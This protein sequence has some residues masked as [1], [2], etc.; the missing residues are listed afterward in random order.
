MSFPETIDLTKASIS[1]LKYALKTTSLTSVELVSRYLHRIAQYDMRGPGLNSVP[2][3]NANVMEEAQ[4]SDDYRASGKPPRSLEG[5]PFTVKDSFKVQGMTVAA[6]SPAFQDLIASDDAFIVQLLRQA[7]A[8]VLGKT[9]MP[10]MADGG[11]QRG[12]Y[13]RAE[14]PCNLEY[15]TT[16]FYSGSSSGCG[17]ST[18][19]SFAAFGLAGE[20]VSSGRAPASNNALVGYSPSRGVI[21]IRG[22]WPLYPTCDVVVPHTKSTS[23]LFD[24]L[25]VIVA[26]D[27]HPRNLDFWRA[28]NSVRIPSASTLRPLDYHMLEDAS[29][30]QGRRIAVPKCFLGIGDQ[31]LISIFSPEV[32]KLFK[33]AVEDLKALGATVVETDFPLLE[34]YAKQDFAG[35]SI[36][37]PGLSKEW[38]SL[39]RCQLM[40][41]AWNDFLRDNGLSKCP[42]LTHVDM[43]AIQPHIA[44]LD[45][46]SGHSVAQNQ[47]RY[48]EMLEAIRI[49]NGSIHE[50]PGCRESLQALED[51]RKSMYDNW[52][53]TNGYYL[54]A[55]PT[56][57]DV[58]CADADENV[59]L[60]QHALQT[61][62]N[63]AN[64]G[65]AL[66]HLGIPCIT[67]PM[68]QMQDKKIPVGI[69]F[70]TKGWTDSDLLRY[71]FAY[72]NASKRRT[73]PSL[74]PQLTTDI[75]VLDVKKTNTLESSLW[76]PRVQ[77]DSVTKD[78][79]GSARNS[80]WTISVSGSVATNDSEIP[81]K[82]I[83]AYLDGELVNNISV[84]GTQWSYVGEVKCPMECYKYPALIKLPRDKV[85]FTVVV[86]ASNGRTASQFVL[87]E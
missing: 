29:A 81:I 72:E 3:I 2:I 30:L 20:T 49:R 32:M 24:V 19:A 84:Q 36:N 43:Q 87:I 83:E 69:T 78:K 46:P 55:F 52:I 57:G 16:A 26:D 33:A 39:K 71:A 1:E 8:V 54:L 7:G 18:T 62:L 25:N 61:G 5:I 73:S 17:S 45:D 42:D 38:T 40:A 22:Q 65:R 75:F 70:S 67:V 48:C 12:L 68:G 6:G 63:Y 10:P 80:G 23:D 76:H 74:T 27:P 56:N 34:Q 79:H 44:P 64:G 9:N 66:K 28:Q 13:D 58:A 37:T 53:D 31:G 77:I 11:N 35:Q 14:S 82:S 60:M 15:A 59:E 50:L 4:A 51:F 47:V 85:M 21:P 86:R 41:M